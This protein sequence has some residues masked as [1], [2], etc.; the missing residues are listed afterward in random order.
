MKLLLLS[1]DFPQQKSAIST[2]S[3]EM[4]KRLASRC[5]DFAVLSLG[6]DLPASG[7]P[8]FD[9]LRLP[10]PSNAP[11]GCCGMANQKP[12]WSEPAA[13]LPM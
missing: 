9:V 11:V 7:A 5:E 13:T 12:I 10:V 6:A 2:W 1:R 8:P 4:A 3:F